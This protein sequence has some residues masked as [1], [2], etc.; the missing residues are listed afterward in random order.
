[1]KNLSTLVTK[2]KVS[3]NAKAI[4]VSTANGKI[5]VFVYTLKGAGGSP[6]YFKTQIRDEDGSWQVMNF[7][8]SETAL[9]TDVE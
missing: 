4:D 9:T 8:T 1:M 6:V 2:D 3:P 5:A 7:R